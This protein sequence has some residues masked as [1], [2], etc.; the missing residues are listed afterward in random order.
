MAVKRTKPSKQSPTFE[1]ANIERL[2]HAS[3]AVDSARRT[4]EKSRQLAQAAG[5][6]IEKVQRR[7]NK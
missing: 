6:L 2:K 3:E 5:E 1:Q 7:K 4:I